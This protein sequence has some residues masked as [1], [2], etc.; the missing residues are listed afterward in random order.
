MQFPQNS[1]EIS[2][3]IR[4]HGVVKERCAAGCR[5]DDMCEQIGECVRHS[6][7]PPGLWFGILTLHPRLTPGA[8]VCRPRC[9]L[10]ARGQG[11]RQGLRR[12]KACYSRCG[13]APL[14]GMLK[15]RIKRDVWETCN[16][17]HLRF[18]TEFQLF[19]R[20]SGA[21]VRNLDSA[22]QADAWGYRMPPAL[23]AVRLGRRCRRG[24]RN[25][26]LAG[27]LP[28]ILGCSLK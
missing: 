10:C 15:T 2:V 6:Y 5:E 9:G 26:T 22:P 11:Y 24:L 21:G 28:G 3:H 18:L 23:G 17:M 13:A 20:P 16:G 27:I 12:T 8:T 1:A 14:T 25:S 19:L 4:S 7:A